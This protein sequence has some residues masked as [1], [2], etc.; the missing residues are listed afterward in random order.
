MAS[1][2]LVGSL[3]SIDVDQ[4]LTREV[5]IGNSK[6]IA[7]G[8][9]V[10]IDT[11]SNGGGCL[12]ATAG[13]KVLGIVTGFVNVNGI[14]IENALQNQAS[15]IDGTYTASSQ[16]Y[17][18]ASNNKT[19]AQVKARVVVDREAI[20]KNDTAGTLAFADEYKFFDLLDSTQIA[21]QNG[22]DS[23]GA[24]LLLYRDGTTATTGYF[25]IAESN[26]DAYVQQ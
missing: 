19:V 21:D 3:K 1:F 20:W 5:I 9:V 2:T 25:K 26:L 8:N 11:F 23:A 13:D 10:K 7:V 22:S 24:F 12:R 16:T 14:G 15:T 17:V 4:P 18:S 6:T